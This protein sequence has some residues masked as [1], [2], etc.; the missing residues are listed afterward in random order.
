MLNLELGGSTSTLKEP[1]MKRA[2]ASLGL[3]FVLGTAVFAALPSCTVGP[4]SGCGP[5]PPCGNDGWM[6]VNDVQAG[7]ECV[8]QACNSCPYDSE[9][10]FDDFGNIQCIGADGGEDASPGPTVG[11]DGGSDA[12]VTTPDA[13]STTGSDASNASDSSDASASDD[14]AIPSNDGAVDG[15]GAADGATI[16][17]G[18]SD[19]TPE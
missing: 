17:D 8:P 7:W 4:E 19:A 3:A 15:G 11:P 18:S 10:L 6:C 12:A 13:S 1:K 16:A 9:C 14:A 2:I 5:N